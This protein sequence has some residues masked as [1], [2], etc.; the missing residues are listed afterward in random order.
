MKA[1]TP[2]ART[3][4][5]RY[6][7][8]AGRHRILSREEEHDLAMRWH[9]DKD[10][11]AFDEL[12]RCNLRFVVKLASGYKSRGV[13]LEDLIQE[14]NLGLIHAVEKYDPS[15][16][17]RLLTYALWWIRAFLRKYFM[18]QASLVKFGTT[19]AHRR[20]ISNLGRAQKHLARHV[21]PEAAN[22]P[23]HIAR[24]LRVEPESVREVMWF[25]AGKDVSLNA[26]IG[27]EVDDIELQDRLPDTRPLPDAVI[28]AADTRRFAAEAVG[29]ALERLD[30]RER[31]IVTQRLL[32]DEPETL[33][34]L[35]QRYGV[36]RER[37]RQIEQAARARLRRSLSG[38]HGVM[39]GRATAQPSLPP[40]A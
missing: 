22:D 5:D 19:R 11:A 23:E 33:H 21:G 6:L 20:M 9:R 4:L 40:A 32:S 7:T 14:G 8:E 12:V 39:T 16:N 17:V 37:A 3:A 18:R 10:R 13:P 1:R 38:A 31:T 25:R 30:P 28:E 35:G 29:R 34:E 2:T 26:P 24:L 15:R 36:S 27:G